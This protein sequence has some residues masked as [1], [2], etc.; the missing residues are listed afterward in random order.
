MRTNSFK[1]VVL[2]LLALPLLGAPCTEEKIVDITV[3]MPTTVLVDAEGSINI[4]FQSSKLRSSKF[5][6]VPTPAQF[7]NMSS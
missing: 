1:A 6:E 3:G 2:L 5:P 4:Q 7:T